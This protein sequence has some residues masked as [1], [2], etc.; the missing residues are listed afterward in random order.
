MHPVIRQSDRAFGLTFAAVF[1]VITAVAWFVFDARVMWTIYVAAAFFGVALAV[2]G[3][4]LPLN[5]LWSL[6]ATRFAAFNNAL[7]LF[8]FFVLIVTP[9][10]LVMRAFG[11]DP[12]QRTRNGGGRSY[13]TPVGRKIDAHTLVDMF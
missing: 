5:R 4:L 10:G 11:R 7:L 9:M 6:F 12:M 3:L 8:V 2:P 13:F 1:A